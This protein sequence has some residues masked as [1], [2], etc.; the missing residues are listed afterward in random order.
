MNELIIFETPFQK[1]IIQRT[2]QAY[3]I[4]VIGQMQTVYE[5]MCY[6]HAVDGYMS[7]L[8]EKV[9]C[10]VLVRYDCFPL[11]ITTSFDELREDDLHILEHLKTRPLSCHEHPRYEGDQRRT[12][13][14]C[15]IEVLN[16]NDLHFVLA[17]TFF[18]AAWSETLIITFTRPT[19]QLKISGKWIFKEAKYTHVLDARDELP[20]IL[21]S[22]DALG[23]MW[24]TNG[25]AFKTVNQLK[26]ILPENYKVD[27]IIDTET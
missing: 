22:H 17:E 11:Y 24:F 1:K 7:E 20:F 26:T 27:H 5:V 6:D 16:A 19:Y 12:N 18:R 25:D 2:L 13:F 3:Q 8:T 15:C 21:P 9:L 14:Y 10:D 23:F 4:N